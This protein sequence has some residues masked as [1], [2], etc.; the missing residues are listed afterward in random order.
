MYT[1]AVSTNSYA[2]Y[3][4]EGP[5]LDLPRPVVLISC[6]SSFTRSVAY[7]SAAMLGL[8]FHDLMRLIEHKAGLHATEIRHSQGEAAWRALQRDSLGRALRDS[9]FG[10]IA[11]DD[12]MLLDPDPQEQI[13]QSAVLVALHFELPNL[14]WRIQHLA[15][16]REIT[17]WHP[18]F[19]GL[20]DSVSQLRPFYQARE[21]QFAMADG[22]LD[23][24]T[25]GV[26]AA[27][28]RVVEWIKESV[29]L[30]QL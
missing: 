13:R 14:Y 2:G 22:Y 24:S 26:S 18:T 27:S 5:L 3:Y 17:E 21:E 12:S 29:A 4:D 15:R 6:L 28:R 10:I 1:P 20:P 19:D 11:A 25:L 16:D 7:R 30:S 8:P 23:A 9:P